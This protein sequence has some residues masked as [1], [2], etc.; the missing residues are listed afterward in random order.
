MTRPRGDTGFT[1]LEM[2]VAIAVLGL[3]SL[4]V[5]K[6]LHLGSDSF[7]RARARSGDAERMRDA[8]R[9]LHQLIA[10]A[11]P[12]F[13][14]ASP[15]DRRVAFAGAPEEADFITR[16]PPAAGGPAMVAARLFLVRH[17]LFLAWRLDLPRSDGDGTLPEQLL[18]I[19]AHIQTVAFAY[20]DPV[21]GW[22]RSWT[23]R[24]LLPG[25]I[26]LAIQNDDERRTLWPD[27]VVETRA[28]ANTD[29]IYDATDIECRRIQ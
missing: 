18:P 3:L 6:G 2:M 10:G 1:L 21:S 8:R 17:T 13:A 7:A 28:T 16:L 20:L 9:I 5:A 26:R 19:A 14:Q 4:S 27:L 24:T 22:Q 23:D 15:D 12:A 11:I 29:C 25:S